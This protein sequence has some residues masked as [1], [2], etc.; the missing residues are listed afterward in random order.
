MNQAPKSTIRHTLVQSFVHLFVISLCVGLSVP[1]INESH[2]LPKAKHAWNAD[3]AAGDIFLESHDSHFAATSLAGG[4]TRLF[5]L[6]TVA[7]LGRALSWS[8]FAWAWTCFSQAAFLPRIL[9]P[10]ALAAWIFAIAYGHWAGE[11]AI[12]G[13]E[14]K[15]IAYPFVLFAMAAI[16][17]R[18]WPAAWIHLGIAVAWH[19]V[20]GGWAGL[21]AAVVWAAHWKRGTS[22][23]VPQIPWWILATLIGLIGVV[24]ALSG[25]GGQDR[26][27][28]I[29]AAQVQVFYR[30]AHHMCPR[31]F[32]W[33]RHVAAAFSLA[34]LA[35]TTYLWRRLEKHT[36]DADRHR[37]IG[38]VF[39]IA[40]ASVAFA[41]CGLLIDLLVADRRMPTYQPS[42]AAKL[43]R[44]YWFRWADVAVPLAWTT[45]VWYLTTFQVRGENWKDQLDLRLLIRRPT[46]HVLLS[47]I[48]TTLVVFAVTIVVQWRDRVPPADHLM[49][50]YTVNRDDDADRYVDW[51]A[52]CQWIRQN[53][54]AD[55]VWLTPKTQQTFKW[56]AQRAEVVCWKD[57]PQDNLSII[58]WYQRVE[59]CRPPTDSNGQRRG[60]TTEEFLKLRQAYEFDWILVDRTVQRLPPRFEIMYPVDISNRSFAVFRVRP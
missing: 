11:W 58:E 39:G 60:R 41:I 28:N 49:V 29:V 13:F 32:S 54:P 33:E 18:R 21:T 25:F 8:L 27:G 53:T 19:P 36:P 30:I 38:L 37:R 59:Q 42:L 43:L 9:S 2:Y 46:G 40:W 34:A 55:S 57:V 26:V 44:F 48:L 5:D 16:L 52:V 23:I 50:Q 31:T 47:T 22:R 6:P 10:I 3:F 1:G 7:W 20:V 15:S 14:A 45:G 17:N 35:I 24:P 51:L 56:Y 12:G 4:L